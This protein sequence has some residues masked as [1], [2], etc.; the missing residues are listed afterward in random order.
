MVRAAP[1][2]GRAL[3]S[4]EA[5]AV[6]EINRV[7]KRFGGVV[8]NEDVSMR[9]PRG[10]IVGLI[11]PNGSGKSTLFNSICGYH[12]IDSGS[13][14]YL[15]QDISRLR[16]ERIARLGLLRTFQQTRIY[17]EM[18]C[19]RNMLISSRAHHVNLL[20]LLQRPEAEDVERAESLLEFV[21]LYEK[22]HLLA[23]SLSF[24]QQKLLEFAMALM[25]EPTMLLLDEPTARDQPDPDQRPDRPSAAREHGTWHH[26]LRDRAQHARRDEPCARDFTCSPTA[27]CLRMAPRTKS[28]PTLAFSKRI[29]AGI[30]VSENGSVARGARGISGYGEGDVEAV[31]SVDAVAREAED[32]ARGGPGREEIE[33]LAPGEPVLRVRGLRAGYGPMEILHGV[34][35]SVGHAQSLCLIGPRTAPANRRSSTPYSALRMSMAARSVRRGPTSRSFRRTGSWPRRESPTSCR[36]VRCFRISPCGRIC[37]WAVT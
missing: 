30:D 27:A 10:G 32:L 5:E 8:A 15:G 4:V 21:G 36:T 37:S 16:T 18:D 33:S 17:A 14:R 26:A 20:A 7:S 3:V 22:R 28:A 25:N 9:I 19:M 2:T 1:G 24:G 31:L 11:G 13:I 29:S 35:L 34:D 6:L 23:G 12:P